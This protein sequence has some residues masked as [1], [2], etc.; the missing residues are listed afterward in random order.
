MSDCWLREDDHREDPNLDV[1]DHGVELD[2]GPSCKFPSHESAGHRARLA[3]EVVVNAETRQEFCV[4]QYGLLAC[5]SFQGW[6]KSEV[7]QCGALLPSVL[8]K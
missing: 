4:T 8:Q 3:L 2:G 7:S 1:L 6:Q 5:I